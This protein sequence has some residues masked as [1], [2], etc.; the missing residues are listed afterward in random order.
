MSNKF[1]TP[2]LQKRYDDLEGIVRDIIDVQFKAAWGTAFN[3][4]NEEDKFAL[5]SI[6]MRSIE[7]HIE[8]DTHED[9]VV[10]VTPVAEQI[11]GVGP[12][13]HGWNTEVFIAGMEDYLP[14]EIACF[15][16]VESGITVF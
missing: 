14:L 11:N 9:V 10:R 2:K 15:Y 1:P 6:H 12:I 16:T 4:A 7:R 5:V 3:L 13:R 8:S